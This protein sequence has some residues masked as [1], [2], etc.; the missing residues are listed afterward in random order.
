MNVRSKFHTISY[1]HKK[2]IRSDVLIDA[3]TPALKVLL[4]LRGSCPTLHRTPST[5]TESAENGSVVIPSPGL[6]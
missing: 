6:L 3:G 4:F 1:K 5:R 2:N